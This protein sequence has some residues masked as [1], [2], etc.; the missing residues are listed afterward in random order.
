LE[1]HDTMQAITK[2]DAANVGTS[3]E[4]SMRALLS[5]RPDAQ[6][7]QFCCAQK[8]RP[9]FRQLRCTPHNS[10]LKNRAH[11]RTVRSRYSGLQPG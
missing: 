4:V 10:A 9:T 5:S 2:I 6:M 7:N 11:S 1:L 8:I 3:F